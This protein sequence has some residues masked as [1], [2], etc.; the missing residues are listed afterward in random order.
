MEGV[1]PPHHLAVG[2]EST[3]SSP[4]LNKNTEQKWTAL[5]KARTAAK[6]AH[7]TR[8]P[9]LTTDF[10]VGLQ[11]TGRMQWL[12]RQVQSQLW[13]ITSF[14]H[15]TTAEMQPDSF[16]SQSWGVFT[17]GPCSCHHKPA[18]FTVWKQYQPED[19]RL[20]SQQPLQA[21]ISRGTIPQVFHYNRADQAAGAK[22]GA[23]ICNGNFTH[24][25]GCVMHRYGTPTANE[26]HSWKI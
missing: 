20:Q 8:Y 5:L 7:I 6:V 2:R 17:D 13:A 24:S 15:V 18:H 22:H 14:F 23:E 4:F 25:L 12:Q 9:N 21:H 3:L 19:S 11:K 1:V 26:G 16:S 10:P